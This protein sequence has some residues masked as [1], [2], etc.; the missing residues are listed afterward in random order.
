MFII[1]LYFINNCI[2]IKEK[3]LHRYNWEHGTITGDLHAQLH[4]D[5]L[6]R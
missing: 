2:Q 4:T 5:V 1:M 6:E 3:N